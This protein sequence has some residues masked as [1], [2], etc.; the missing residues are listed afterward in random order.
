VTPKGTKPGDRV[1]RTDRIDPVADTSS[2]GRSA[3]RS[4]SD[5]GERRVV[6]ESSRYTP[7]QISKADLPSPRWV[8]V[9]MWT[10]LGAGAAVIIVNYTEFLW[11]QSGLVLLGGLASILAGIMVATQYR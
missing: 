6:E 2:S 5:D 4:A 1:A 7:K 11:T 9:L 8:P 3:K 10:L